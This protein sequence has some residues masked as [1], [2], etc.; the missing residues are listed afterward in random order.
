M[1]VS[2]QDAEPSQ[3]VPNEA[4]RTPALDVLRGLIKRMVVHHKGANGGLALEL[5]GAITAMN[6]QAQPDALRGVDACSVALVAGA[7]MGVCR[8]RSADSAE[9]GGLI[10]GLPTDL[11]IS[12]QYC[13]PRLAQLAQS[14]VA[15]K[16][17]SG[18]GDPDS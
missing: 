10:G 16:S 9:R 11:P 6:E 8:Q 14:G 13:P 17:R 12:A 2:L 3:T 18:S 4:I 5:E 1:F 15:L 7:R